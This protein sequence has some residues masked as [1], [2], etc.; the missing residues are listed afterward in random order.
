TLAPCVLLPICGVSA[1]EIEPLVRFELVR[2]Y[3][4]PRP[5]TGAENEHRLA[6]SLFACAAIPLCR[7]R[8][9]ER[10]G[11]AV[12]VEISQPKHRVGAAEIRG[13]AVHRQGLR[14]ITRHAIA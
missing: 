5:V 2:R 10:H 1:R 11:F 13:L 8:V 7:L 12:L 4:A 6:L 9:V 3:A 14:G